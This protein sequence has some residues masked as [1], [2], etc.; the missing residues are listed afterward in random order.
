MAEKFFKDSA[1]YI[2]EQV[3]SQGRNPE[4]AARLKEIIESVGN[5][6]QL[7]FEVQARTPMPDFLLQQDTT[8]II[9]A[10]FFKRTITKELSVSDD[11][12]PSEKKSELFFLPGASFSDNALAILNDSAENAHRLK[13]EYIGTE[14]LLLGLVQQENLATAV[15]DSLGVDKGKLRSAVEFIIGKGIANGDEKIGLTPRAKKVLE[16]SYD[17]S[18]KNKDDFIGSHHILLGTIREHEG[19]AYGVLESLGVSNLEKTRDAVKRL[20]SVVNALDK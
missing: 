2:E 5:T 19:I 18:K 20:V 14:H 3:L 7:A 11:L 9:N 13:N 15:L 6:Y 4:V 8:S 12:K 17:E 10:D 16:L 1:N